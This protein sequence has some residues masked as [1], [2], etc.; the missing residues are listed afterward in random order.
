[1]IKYITYNSFNCRSGHALKDIFTCYILASVVDG[2][3]VLPQENWNANPSCGWG[4]DQRIIN[5]DTSESQSML[6]E[7]DLIKINIKE[8][9]PPQWNGMSFEYFSNLKRQ[10]EEAPQ[11]SIVVLSRTTRV[12]FHQLTDWYNKKLIERD[13]FADVLLVLRNLYFKDHEP[14]TIDCLSIHIRR[15]DVADPDH[16]LNQYMYWAVDHFE[17]AIVSFRKLHPHVPIYIF[18]ENKLSDDLKVLERHDNLRLVL[19]DINSLKEDIDHM[20]SSRFFMPCNSGLSTWV[21]Y[22]SRGEIII[23][24]DKEIKHFHR[25]HVW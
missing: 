4:Y 9:E 14:K 17:Q 20:I 10:I 19:G 12:L 5:F 7:G 23:S 11:G 15:G 13:L 16:R 1:M 18:S 21:S 25:E 22:I 3:E 24:K 2:L 8:P 6:D